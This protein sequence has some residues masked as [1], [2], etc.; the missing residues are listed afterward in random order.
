MAEDGKVVIELIGKDKATQTFVKSMKDMQQSAQSLES[1]ATSSFA[2]MGTSITSF[3]SA[4]AGAIAGIAASYV[5]MKG[6]KEFWSTIKEV[7]ASEAALQKMASRLNAT[8]TE[9]S[10]LGVV[11]RKTGMDSEAFNIALER[12]NKN[13]SNAVLKAEAMPEAVDEFGE[14]LEKGARLMDEL[15]LRADVLQKMPLPEKLKTIASAMKDNIQPADQSRVALELF[16]RA[17]GAL[18]IALKAGPEAIQKWIDR[19]IALGITTDEMAKKGAELKTATGDL[20]VAWHQFAVELTD[21][22][23]PS[24]GYAINKLTDLI[25]A[26]RSAS[27][28]RA[29]FE[30][31]AAANPLHAGDWWTPTLQPGGGGGGG[32]WGEDVRKE[33][34]RPTPKVPTTGGK[35]GSGSGLESAQ[36]QLENFIQTMQAE[37]AKASGDGI[38][39]LDAWYAK[40]TRILEELIKK[41]GESAAARTALSGAYAGKREKIEEDFNQFVAK[42]S[43][44][45]YVEIEAQ[46]RGWL[47]KYQGLANS[48]AQIA[49]IKSQKIWLEDV[50][51]YEARAGLEKGFLDTLA[52]SSPLLSEQLGYKQKA[53]ALEIEIDRYTL[54]K[55]F[56]EMEISEEQ[57][58]QYRGLLALTNAAKKY[59]LEREGWKTQGIGGG[60][61]ILGEDLRKEGETWVADSFVS[62]FKS[63]RSFLEDSL[64]GVMKGM[65]RGEKLDIKKFGLSVG[66]S[67]IDGMVKMGSRELI[68]LFTGTLEKAVT[69]LGGEAAGKA[70]G[71]VVGKAGGDIVGGVVGQ[72]PEAAAGVELMAAA[73]ALTGSSLLL[74]GSSLLLDLSSMLLAGSSLLL[75]GTSLLLDGSAALL[76]GAAVMLSQAALALT[77]AAAVDAVPILHQG[78]I[79]TAHGGLNLLANERL[80]KAQLG[81]GIIS[82]RGM[83]ALPPGGFDFINQ[84]G[85]LP[86]VPVRGEAGGGGGNV[87]H[88]PINITINPRQEMTQS[89]YN[90]HSRMIVKSLNRAIGVRGQKL[91]DGRG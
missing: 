11:A 13:I 37:T 8:V 85:G 62:G 82:N 54:E 17:G 86:V 60:M 81:E 74:D 72:A 79:I 52:S 19:Q 48:E 20:T 30:A 45:A 84:G 65:L 55:K 22:V 31:K 61:K 46:A 64:S 23:A 2:K 58:D 42:E 87:V 77:I 35:G 44:N 57:K 63:A 66:D 34:S 70:I 25:V 10:S 91:G 50:K 59:S 38:A 32:G 89:D 3:A 40:E 18:V 29:E 51:Q 36:R 26:A 28:A 1:G 53:L 5:G 33:P 41:T 49:A 69:S 75:D 73:L 4:H 71:R 9:L 27:K 21:V 47:G 80:I 15:G 76:G 39:A 83:A 6:V 24:I 12:M 14:P 67:I 88:A 16:G 68:K 7:S 90:R 78:G 56:L 43:G